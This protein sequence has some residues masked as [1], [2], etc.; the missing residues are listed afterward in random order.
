MDPRKNPYAP[1]A[2]SAPPELAG[3][4]DVIERASVALDR[5]REGRHA[6]SLVFYGLRGVG[7]TVLL[8][9]LR[10][11]AES[12]GIVPVDVEAPEGRSL[13]ATLGLAL[14]AALI[15]MSRGEATK[16]IYQNAL[17]VLANF[18]KAAKVKFHDIEFS[19]DFSAEA[20]IAD[21]G[22][23][24][25][26]LTD[27]FLCVGNVASEQRTAV[28]LFIDELQYINEQ[29]LAALITALHRASQKQ[30]PVTMV[31]AGLP[32]L[33]G[34]MGRAKSYAE[35]LFEFAEIG[36]LDDISAQR[37]LRL[38]ARHEG[39]EF[40]Q[41]AINAIIQQTQVSFGFAL[42]VCRLRKNAMREP[43]R[44]WGQDHIALE[45]SRR[46]WGRKIRR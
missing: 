29:Q 41:E 18:V 25:A 6:R 32:Q 13:P 39:V 23:L 37:A 1:G 10:I 11:D 14:R 30:L 26:D 34:Q 36:P 4:D 45:K 5:I 44:N 15:R 33:L 35:R 16:R 20:G 2:G 21:S 38:P 9:R 28:V 31:A 3:R 42:T 27:I 12:Q 19:M 43:W 22:D 17:G 8:Q 40:T 46:C 7:K 24:E